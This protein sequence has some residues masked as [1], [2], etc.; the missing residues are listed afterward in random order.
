MQLLFGDTPSKDWIDGMAII[1][2]VIIV[3]LVSSINNYIKEIEF[4]EFQ[5][6]VLSDRKVCVI[7][8]G[9]DE[10]IAES[11]LLVGDLLKIE[12]GMTIPVDCI[13]VRGLNVTIDESAMTGEID[14]EEKA[15]IDECQ[16]M[17]EKFLNSHP[18]YIINESSHSKIM[19]PIIPSGTTVLSGNGNA[20]VIAVGPNSE[21]GK[22][23]ST[24]EA[25][26]DEDEA[27]E[28]QKKLVDVAETI[29]W[30]FLNKIDW[31]NMCNNN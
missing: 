27:T 1:L 8:D 16:K 15:N 20:L 23:I 24:I 30:V 31:I 19:S 17:K 22:I 6:I 3:I 4:R 29:G 5:K 10:E 14:P 26:K 13:L 18:N 21:K 12:E 25:N 11:E 28:L 7:R 9:Q 2:A